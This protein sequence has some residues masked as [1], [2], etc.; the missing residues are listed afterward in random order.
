MGMSYTLVVFLIILGAAACVGMGWGIWSLHNG[1]QDPEQD[2]AVYMREV[3]LRQH[4][5]L[6]NAY[7]RKYMV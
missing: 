6:Q 4:E 5:M 2:Q 3:R 7:G 1:R